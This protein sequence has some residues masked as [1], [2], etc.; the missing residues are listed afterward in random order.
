M[1]QNNNETPRIFDY[2][3]VLQFLAEYYKF[4]KSLKS[5]FS[6]EVWADELG[7]KSRSYVRMVLFGKKKI[8]Q[9]FIESFC[10][11]NQLTAS[12]SEYFFALVKFN[13]A[14]TLRER[15][16]YGQKLTQI[17]KVNGRRSEIRDDLDFPLTP[18]SMQLL[19]LLTFEDL[20]P[21]T[22]TFAHLLKTSEEEIEATLQ[23]LVSLEVVQSKQSGDQTYWE[24]THTK[25]SVPENIGSAAL[26]RFH[27]L[28]LEMAAQKTEH[29]PREERRY[30][31]LLL[32]MSS[33][34]LKEYYATVENFAAEQLARFQANSIK[35]RKLFQVNLNVYPVAEA[36]EEQT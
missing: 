12:E 5:G 34:E 20:L 2:L 15:Q 23:K 13:Q 35:G 3:D 32:P 29:A 21:T 25:F 28:S 27:Q 36:P 8:S 19:T 1:A 10:Q 17:L 11:K 14:A 33:E 30:R 6:Y 16:T 9:Y 26:I 4:R 7:F 24:T 18:L 31:S 22:A